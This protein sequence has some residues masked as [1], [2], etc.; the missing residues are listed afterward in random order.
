VLLEQLACLHE[1]AHPA[2]RGAPPIVEAHHVRAV[3]RVALQP[4]QVQGGLRHHLAAQVARGLAGLGAGASTAHVDVHQHVEHEPG[5][6]HRRPQLPHVVRMVHHHERL[7]LAAQHAQQPPDLLRA[8]H[9]GRD[10]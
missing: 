7:G 6:G 3:A 9:L 2:S 1:P 4:A 5:L 10:Q 8:D